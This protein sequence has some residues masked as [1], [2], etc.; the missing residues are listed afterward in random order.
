MKLKL[1]NILLTC[2]A[3]LL[4]TGCAHTEL[5]PVH[6]PSVE[7]ELRSLEKDIVRIYL[8]RDGALMERI[9]APEW[10]FTGGDGQEVNRGQEIEKLRSGKLIINKLDVSEMTV[11]D[12]GQLA[13][14]PCAAPIPARKAAAPSTG[15]NVSPTSSSAATVVGSV[16]R[17][18]P[19]R[20]S[21]DLHGLATP[22]TGGTRPCRCLSFSALLRS[23]AVI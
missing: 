6:R 10:T 2:A 18:Q 23:S 13:V 4:L 14:S 9:F 5:R 3:V 16:S 8:R 19:H 7:Q 1:Q 22:D 15:T 20:S 21:R 17:R 12:Y 11:R